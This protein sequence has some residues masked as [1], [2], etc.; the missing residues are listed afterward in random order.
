MM[1]IGSRAVAV[2][3]LSALSACS[4]GGGSNSQNGVINTPQPNPTPTPTSSAQYPLATDFTKDRIES[5]YGTRFERFRAYGHNSPGWVDVALQTTTTVGAVIGFSYQANPIGYQATY[6]NERATFANATAY[7]QAPWLGHLDYDPAPANPHP[8]YFR[9][10]K[11]GE[12]AKDQLNYVGL[13]T[14]SDFTQNFEHD[15]V[16]G[17]REIMRYHLY[18]AETLDTEIPKTGAFVYRLSDLSRFGPFDVRMNWDTSTI[19]GTV[20]VPCPSGE[21]CT[22]GDLGD[23]TFSG[24]LEGGDRILGTMG[25]SA[26]YSGTFVGNFYG[27]N[28]QE[29]GIVGDLRHATRAQDIFY[30]MAKR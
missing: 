22:N 13:V 16:D 29:I 20:R 1:R 28:A 19:T 9:V 30:A 5:G 8:R 6:L 11:R 24:I 25:G 21:T 27:P 17:D 14:W 12:T 10:V 18:G 3:A 26:G 15:G 4:G 7:T 2:V 23:L